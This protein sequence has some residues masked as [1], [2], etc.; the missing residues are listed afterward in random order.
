MRSDGQGRCRAPMNCFERYL[1]LWVFLCIIAGIV[2]GQVLP[3]LF[4][5]LGAWKSPRST[6]RS[7]C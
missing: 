6:C 3:A 4:Q 1:T 5:A 7:A 2:L